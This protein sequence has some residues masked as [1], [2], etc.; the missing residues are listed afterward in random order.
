MATIKD[1]AQAAGVS[2]MT[3]TR[4]LNNP[5]CVREETKKRVTQVMSDLHYS[6]NIAAKHLVSN[7]TGIIDLYI[8]EKV[9]LSNPFFTHLIIGVSEV[10]SDN[11]YSLMILRNLNRIHKCDGYIVSGLEK[12]EIELFRTLSDDQNRPLVLFGHTAYEDVDCIDVDNVLGAKMATSHLLDLDHKKI[13]MINVA[14]DKD[15]T[16]DRLNGYKQALA[17]QGLPFDETLLIYAENSPTG[18]AKAIRQLLAQNT[19]DA[20]FC[21]TDTIAIGAISEIHNNKL[22]VPNDIAV[23]GFD[24]LGHNLLSTPT[25]TSIR[26]PVY[27]I[28][29]LLA[30]TLLDRMNG[31][32]YKISQTIAPVFLE[33]G[34]DQ[35]KQIKF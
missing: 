14:E 22:S 7:R 30:Q 3:V 11:M 19:I 32:T 28:G 6:P 16:D 25:I 26:Q 13:A 17:E 34:S 33:G 10:L 1:V 18:G 12:G 8:P 9:D 23:M 29:G 35:Q 15:Y 5:E 24:G 21:A 27:E 2:T 31:R 20:V 4:V